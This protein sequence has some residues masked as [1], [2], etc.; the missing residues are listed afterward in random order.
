[1]EAAGRIGFPVALK[2]QAAA[3]PHKSDA[4]AV[5]LDINDETQLAQAWAKLQQ[6]GLRHP[7]LVIDGIL[8]EA[9]APRGL[10]MI[11]GARRD[12]DWGP[13]TLVGLGGIWAEALN[14]VRVLPVDLD[15]DEVSEEI[16]KLQGAPLLRGM[17]GEAARDVT[18]LATIVQRIGALLAA[19]PDIQEVD[20]NPVTVYGVGEGVLALDALIVTNTPNG[21]KTP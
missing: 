11:V 2:L 17:R 12:P 6:I 19:Q 8:I 4:G 16:G 21:R 1:M 3:L 10:E 20:L 15:L 5:L 13:V 18:A 9:M 7:D 14:D